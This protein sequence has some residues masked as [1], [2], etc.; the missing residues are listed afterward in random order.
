MMRAVP[1]EDEHAE[2]PHVGFR[3]RRW[4]R[5]EDDLRSWMTTP[6]GRFAVWAAKR[7]ADAE[8]AVRSG[9][10]HTDR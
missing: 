4:R 10:P 3:A 5:F 8:P 1:P 9:S 7:E 6:E 2:F